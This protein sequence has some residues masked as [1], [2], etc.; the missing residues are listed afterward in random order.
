MPAAA[1]PARLTG[2]GRFT[3]AVVTGPRAD[4]LASGLAGDVCDLA[5]AVFAAP[6]WNQTPAH[7]RLL[8]DRMLADAEQAAFV[9]A[10]AFN[11][12]G[13]GLAGFAYGVP[14]WPE[15]G[16]AAGALTAGG[17]G[18]FE[19]CELAVSPAARGLGAGRALHDAVV[20]ASG[21]Q[22]RWLVTHPAARPAVAL[23]RARGWHT[24]RLFPSRTDASIRLLMARSS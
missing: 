3:V 12:D 8:T 23:Y 9:L 6:P 14:R 10:V 1:P 15:P 19:F 18:P 17:T 24:R 21:P 4:A 16:L 5:A 20:G 13:P 7:A 2:A 22:Q 11:G